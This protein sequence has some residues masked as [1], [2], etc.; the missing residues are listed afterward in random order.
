MY[1]NV[2]DPCTFAFK[3]IIDHIHFCA[4]HVT[5]LFWH[6]RQTFI[7]HLMAW[8][9][10]NVPS[11]LKFWYMHDIASS[12]YWRYRINALYK[13]P[14][15]IVRMTRDLPASNKVLGSVNPLWKC[16]DLR[17]QRSYGDGKVKFR[18]NTHTS[19]HCN[20]RRANVNT[21]KLTETIWWN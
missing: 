13:V 10:N 11:L 17:R 6:T 20:A 16:P 9:T 7:R 8:R 4:I 15:I 21:A 5:A 3:Y 19:I 18:V 2:L 1:L 14:S 12:Q